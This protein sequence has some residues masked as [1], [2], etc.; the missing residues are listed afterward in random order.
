MSGSLYGRGSEKGEKRMNWERIGA[1]VFVAW[2]I[3]TLWIVVVMVG[4]N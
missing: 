1:Y 2:V 4:E 3:T